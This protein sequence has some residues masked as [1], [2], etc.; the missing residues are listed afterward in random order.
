MCKRPELV[1]PCCKVAVTSRG[2]HA[3][4]TSPPAFHAD[5]AGPIRAIATPSPL[6]L[7]CPAWGVGC[8]TVSTMVS[9]TLYTSL[10]N[11]LVSWR[12]VA[13]TLYLFSFLMTRSIRLY[14]P[15]FAMSCRAVSTGPSQ[16]T[17]ERTFQDPK[18]QTGER[19]RPA[20]CTFIGRSLTR[21][22]CRFSAGE[23]AGDG[24]SGDINRR[25]VL[26]LLLLLGRVRQWAVGDHSLVRPSAVGEPCPLSTRRGPASTE[27][28]LR[29]AWQTRV[30]WLSL[31]LATD[32]G[33]SPGTEEAF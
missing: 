15:S 33:A 10:L 17:S 4:H 22:S 28:G 20:L 5:A 24:R 26:A 18:C 7:G 27:P 23:R 6:F 31:L 13:T 3:F 16:S 30:V 21:E 19:F 2:L 25:P 12:A 8:P 9:P 29:V 32:R 14:S 1:W 11:H